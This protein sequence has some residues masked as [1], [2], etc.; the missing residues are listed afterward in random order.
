MDQG[1]LRVGGRIGAAAD[2]SFDVKHPVILDGRSQVAKLIV[3]H[4]HV[5]AGHGNQEMVVNNL[6]QK[7]WL[8]RMRPTVKE[9]TKCM[10]CKLR[11]VKPIMPKTGDLPAARVAHHQ[12]PFTHCGVDLFGP[13]EVTVGR[14]REKRYGVIFTCL[15]VRAIHLETVS[16]LSTD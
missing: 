12:R 13:M 11:R 3:R 7:Y 5:K 16:S 4:Y 1:V 10:L 14:R 6:K 15:T 9:I 8:I 2:I